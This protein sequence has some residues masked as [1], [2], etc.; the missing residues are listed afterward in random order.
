MISVRII[1]EKIFSRKIIVGELCRYLP[2][3]RPPINLI[4]YFLFRREC[5]TYPHSQASYSDGQWLERKVTKDQRAIEEYLSL[6]DLRAKKLLHV[7]IGSSRIAKQCA[8]IE[9]CSIDGITVIEAEKTYA[10]NLRLENYSVRLMNKNNPESLLGLSGNYAYI[11]DNDIAAYACCKEH[12]EKMLQHYLS[13]LV[14]G[15]KI[16][17]GT[18]SIGYFD[19]GFPLPNFYRKTLSEKYNCLFSETHGIIKITPRVSL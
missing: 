3:L 2:F 7:G 13:I 5:P 6:K 10:D 15:G 19:T 12:F 1:G 8:K 17:A 14:P 4:R 9:G 18:I 11:I 16:L